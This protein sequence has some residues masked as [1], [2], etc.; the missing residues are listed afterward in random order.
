M[1]MYRPQRKFV[2]PSQSIMKTGATL[3]LVLALR[4]GLI[5]TK[6]VTVAAI[7]TQFNSG[8]SKKRRNNQ[9]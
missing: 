6:K 4:S 7:Q 1:N 9:R 8:E 3:C 2:A 5:N